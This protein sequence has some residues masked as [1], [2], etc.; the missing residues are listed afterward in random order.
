MFKSPS[1]IFQV[2]SLPL[3]ALALFCGIS[4]P[5]LAHVTANPDNGPAGQ[6]F[7]TKFRVSHGCEGSDTTAVSIKFPAGIVSLKPQHKDGWKVEIKKSKLDKPVPAGHGKIATEQVDEVIWSGSVLPD[8]EY[9]EFGIV[10][11]LPE[12]EATLWFPVTQICQKGALEWKEIPA[13]GQQWHDLKSP[14]PFVKIS[15]SA[16]ESHHH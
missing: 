15:P 11:R 4:A 1:A 9:D 14:A 5:A 13:A 6:Y 16:D 10:L 3:A 12:T 8:A 7:E 2:R